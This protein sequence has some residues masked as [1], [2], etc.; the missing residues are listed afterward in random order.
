MGTPVV[1]G[2][3]SRMPQVLAGEFKNVV[4]E[5]GNSGLAASDGK[6]NEESHDELVAVPFPP[7]WQ[8]R[9]AKPFCLDGVAP[10]SAT[11]GQCSGQHKQ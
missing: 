3:A 4:V 6:R 11:H 8:G 10:L 7:L 1:E 9:V 5:L 2:R